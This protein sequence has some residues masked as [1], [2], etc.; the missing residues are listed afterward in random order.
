MPAL[1]LCTHSDPQETETPQMKAALSWIHAVVETLDMRELEAVITEDFTYEILPKSLGH[2]P[3]QREEFLLYADAILFRFVKDFR[4]TIHQVVQ[5][6]DAVVL[7][8]TCQA[9]SV[10][11]HP[12]TNEY[13]LVFSLSQQ[14]DGQFK[15]RAVKEFLDSKYCAEFFPAERRRR[16]ELYLRSRL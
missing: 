4:A 1:S 15:V 5:S 16:R 14:V 8:A 6:W 12:Y 3:R 11:G 10:T 13:M 9:I 7:Y 2:H